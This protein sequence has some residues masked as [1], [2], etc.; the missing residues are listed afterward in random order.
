MRPD[1]VL[2]FGGTHGNEWTGS[3]LI[4]KYETY[5]K[6]RFPKLKLECILANPKAREKNLRFIDEDLNRAFAFLNEARPYSF[7]HQRAREIQNLIKRSPGLVIDLHT[8]TSS[9][10]QTIILSNEN[11]LT[12]H[13]ASALK[14][15]IPQLKILLAPD[16]N[17]KYLASQ[18]ETGI[19][20]EV[21]PTP[22]GLLVG[23]ILE[24]TL[25]LLVELLEIYQ[26]T[27]HHN[28]QLEVYEEVTDIFYPESENQI[29]SYINP[30]FQ[31]KNFTQIEG[32]Y[33]PFK[34]FTGELISLT[35]S[36][37]LYPIFIN[38]AAYYPHKLAFTLCRKKVL[39]F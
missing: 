30:D 24:Q 32:K 26:N 22:Q 10:G 1:R 38:E 39:A 27:S 18:S 20:V 3:V 6:E 8:T 5:L 15:K 13:L 2:I 25:T 35:T 29:N 34:A 16:P 4:E 23:K 28:G 11:A 31:D 9:M 12:L 33:T 17:K 7:E 14:H 36:E 21:G 19:I 37:K